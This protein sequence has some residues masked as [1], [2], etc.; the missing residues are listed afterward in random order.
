LDTRKRKTKLIKKTMGRLLKWLSA[1]M[2]GLLV[3]TLIALQLPYVQNRLFGSF[4]QYLSHTTQFSITHQHFQLKWWRHASLTGLVIKDPQDNLIVAADQLAVSINPLQLLTNMRITLK[5]VCVK[6]AQVYLHKESEQ[7]YGIHVLLQRLAGATKP[8]P[9]T[10]RAPWFAIESASLQN[11][12]FSV[13]DRQAVPLQDVFDIRH[14]TIYNVNAELANLEV[15]ARKWAVDICHF[16]G[17]HA[18]SPLLINHLSTLLVVTPDS[19]QCKA[20]QLQTACSTLEG[21]CTLTYDPLTLPAAFKDNAYLTACFHNILVTAEDLAV[22]IPYFEQHRATYVLSGTLEGKLNDLHISDFQLGFGKKGSHFKSCLSLQGL[23][24]V[25]EVVFDMELQQGVLHTQDLLPYL[26]EKYYNRIASFNLVETKGRFYGT[27]SD[28]MAQATFDTSLGKIATNLEVQMDPASERATYKGTIATSNFEL[29]AW[30][31]NPAVQQL[32]MHGQIDGA[33]LSLATARFQLEASIS[34]LGV[35]NYTYENVY[36]NGNFARA[37]FQGKLI[38]DDPHLKLRADASVN[39]NR[40]TENIAVEGVLDKA[41]LQALRLTDR[42]ATLRARLSIATQ[43]LSWDDIKADA[44]L[45]QFCFDLEGRE[46]RLDTLHVHTDRGDFGR[47]LKVDS[48]LFAFEAEGDFSYPI[49]ANDLSQFIQSYQCCL[50]REKL[51]T[52][53]YSLEPYALTY[54]LQCRNMNPLIRVLGI[55]AYVSPNTQFEGFF[56]QQEG[57]TFSLRLAEARSLAFKKYRW[58]G[59]QLELSARQSK[60]GQ[61]VSAAV[62]LVSK[63]QQ[64]AGLNN[65][66]DLVLAISWKD[67]QVT[68]SGNMAQQESP[69]QINLQGQAVLSESAIEIVLI[70]TQEAH[71]NNQWHVHPKNRITLGR[72]RTQFQDFTFYK[73]QQQVSLVGI[74]SADPAEVLHV[75]IKDYSLSNRNLFVNQQLAGVL[76]ATAVL[77]GTLDQLRMDGDITL[78]KL[79]ID[80]ALIGDM[81]GHANWNHTLQRFN[82]TCQVDHLKQQTV[83]IH[84]FY[85]PFKEANNLQ[86]TACFAS[87]QLASLEP[88]IANHL[89]QLSGELNGT[90][91]IHGSPTNLRLTGG[92]QVTDAAVRINYFNMLYQASGVF[93][94]A[95]QAINIAALHLSDDQQGKAVLQGSI[96]YSGA[97]D[98]K[99]DVTGNITNLRLLNTASKD[100]KHVYGTGILSGSLSASGP[101]NNMVVCLKAKTDPGTNI[102]I[103]MNRGRNKLAQYG[104]IRFV[105][106]K[107]QH[108]DTA[109]QT[110]QAVLKGFKLVL[111]L[112]ITPD[113]HTELILAAKTGDAIK[114]RGQGN[115]TLEIDTGG[116]LTMTGGFEFLEGAYNLALYRIVNRTF[117]ILPESRITWHD[118]PTQGILNIQAVYEQRA[119]LASLL[120]GPIVAGQNRNKYPVQVLVGL[121]G[122]LLSPKKSFSVNFLEYPGEFSSVV[123]EFKSKA[124]QDKKYVETQVLSLLLFKEFARKKILAVGSKTLSRNFSA[125]ASQ[126]LRNLTSKINDNL[127]VDIEVDFATSGSQD[128]D[129]LHLDLSYQLTDRLRVSRK[130]SISGATDDVSNTARLVGDWTAAYV[131]TKDGRLKAKLYNKYITNAAYVDS[132][133]TTTLSG[134]VS[135]LYTKRFD[136]WKELVRG[137]KR[138]AKK[139]AKNK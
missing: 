88:F 122:A 103:P 131:L 36:A 125:L 73:G 110:K 78:E 37:F 60:D 9:N 33:G 68:F 54:Q 121:Q 26:D 40:G 16:T 8:V 90:V 113:A 81:R 127:E 24:D 138:A 27:L 6:G 10:Q 100:N 89:S 12:V 120:E 5:K 92:L 49:L 116:V 107:A 23:L 7:A 52:P 3:S 83:A 17:R 99:I 13:D 123:D 77:Q 134:G 61:E 55:D 129:T 119:A 75:K 76:N 44:T 139:V 67:D 43:G 71:T 118:S 59:T 104:F 69:H 106:M 115:I 114:G 109:E 47:M 128:L 66:E 112:E 11:T 21:D 136:Q 85:E 46:I 65:T 20:L 38:I 35:N 79:T 57:I 82:M 96:A 19:V 42:R 15:Q 4:L 39:L 25:Q 63:E 28:F 48:A 94:F 51:P 64:W 84:G 124:K 50:M 137:H 132:G 111:L 45:H 18:G 126:Q 70:P 30:L 91:H 34:K 117:K 97:E 80:H 95:D 87:A 41:C 1:A 93:T 108:Q 74:L 56:L 29:G 31:N 102:V 86:L 105:N 101:L 14:F 53:R 135:L 2:L 133:D 22:F 32:T 58:E 62:R 130:G 72:S 98:F